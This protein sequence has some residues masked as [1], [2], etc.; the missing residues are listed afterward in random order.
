M[1]Q[2]ELSEALGVRQADISRIER[3]SGNPTED[4]LQRLAFA[5][6]KRVELV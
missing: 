5:L 1:S 4:T 6:D 2:G 3:D